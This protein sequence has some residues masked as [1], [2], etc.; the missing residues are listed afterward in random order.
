MIVEIIFLYGP[1]S[2]EHPR[3]YAKNLAI[4]LSFLATN[5]YGTETSEQLWDVRRDGVGW[6]KVRPIWI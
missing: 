1:F 6:G 4:F 3:P 2:G 5:R